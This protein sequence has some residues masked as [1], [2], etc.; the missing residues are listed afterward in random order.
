MAFWSIFQ[1]N[2]GCVDVATKDVCGQPLGSISLDFR[3]VS[4]QLKIPENNDD[5][6]KTGLNQVI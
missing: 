2:G 5:I 3:R 6:E 1:P 4:E